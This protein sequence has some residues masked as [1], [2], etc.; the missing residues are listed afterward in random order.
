[1]ISRLV[2]TLRG[3]NL[4]TADPST[5]PARLPPPPAAAP[6]REKRP[7]SPPPALES[8]AESSKTAAKRARLA[9]PGYRGGGEGE[10]VLPAKRARKQKPIQVLDFDF[11]DDLE[12]ISGGEG[13]G[14]G[15]GQ[16]AVKAK[17]RGG[18]VNSGT[19]DGEKPVNGDGKKGEHSLHSRVVDGTDTSAAPRKRKPDGAFSGQS[20]A[21]GLAQASKG[22]IREFPISLGLIPLWLG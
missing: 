15:A 12:S 1:M 5:G 9:S 17:G 4:S 6:L 19:R 13:A 14:S 18:K 10:V 16:S 3:T 21:A 2:S 22:P 8:E 20:P 11:E 7:A